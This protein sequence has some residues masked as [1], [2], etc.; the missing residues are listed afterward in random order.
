[1]QLYSLVGRL[2][3]DKTAKVYIACSKYLELMA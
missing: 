3:V 1:M 2:G